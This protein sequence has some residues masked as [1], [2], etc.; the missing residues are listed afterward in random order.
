MLV[1]VVC[2]NCGIVY[3]KEQQYVNSNARLGHKNYCSIECQSQAKSKATVTNCAYCGKKVTRRLHQFKRSKSG[4]VFCSR[5]CA[6]SYNNSVH[7]QYNN[8]PN[9][10]DGNST[11]RR[12][13]LEYYGARCTVCGYD[14]E[15]T[16]EVHHRNGNRQDNRIENLD[17]LCPTH[18]KEYELGIRSYT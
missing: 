5:S 9:F 4:N 12:R 8:H 15:E 6:T 3:Q 13:A 16:L 1:D 11:Y 17:V 7:K 18:H 14:I 10:V 2:D